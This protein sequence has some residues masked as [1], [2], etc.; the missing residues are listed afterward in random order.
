MDNKSDY[1]GFK[2]R[3]V[4]LLFLII[5]SFVNAERVEI[6]AELVSPNPA[7]VVTRHPQI[8]IKY[9]ADIS[10]IIKTESIRFMVNNIDYTNYIRMDLTT[11]E[12]VIFF[13]SI[14]PLNIGKNVIKVT[15]KLIN[16]DVF[17]NIFYIDINP[18]LSPQIRRYLDLINQSSSNTEKSR[19]CYEL[20]KYY[21]NQGYFL[22]ALSY[23]E[24]AYKLDNSNKKAKQH[25]NKILSLFPSKAM[26][27]LNIVLDVS[28][29]NVDVLKRN[30]IYLFRCVIENY[31]DSTIEFNLS[32]FLLVSSNKYY[33]PIS[34]PYE[35]LRKMVQKNLMT[36]DDFAI[37]NYLLSKD[38]YYFDYPDNFAVN[39]YSQLKLDLVFHLTQ[40]QKNII[41]Q[42]FK[43][44]EKNGKKKELPA[45]FKLSF[46]I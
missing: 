11:P 39:S 10:P 36:I 1:E 44:L 9:P 35:Y 34:D 25:Y 14:K 3:I 23:Y 46:S 42:F 26:K 45:Y 18:R 37:S 13:Y 2:M 30:N 7:S 6:G 40:A 32:N 31:R 8:I 27:L 20:G 16:D 4:I 24:Q 15:G 22:D 28:M 38:I 19:Y 5:L 41:F 21:E 12:I 17:E 33:Q 29:L 43:P